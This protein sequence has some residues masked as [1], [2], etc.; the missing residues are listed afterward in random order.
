MSYEMT[1][2]EEKEFI[3]AATIAALPT[4]LANSRDFI[5]QSTNTNTNLLSIARVATFTAMMALG[6]VK[7]ELTG[8]HV[9]GTTIE[10]TEWSQ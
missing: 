8:L 9:K 3:K 6:T 4:I 1:P 5:N 2:T 10:E 7:D